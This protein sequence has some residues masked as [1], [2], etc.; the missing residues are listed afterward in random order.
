MRSRPLALC[1]ALALLAA[2][3]CTAIRRSDAMDTERMLAAAGFQL[4]LA[5]SPARLAKVQGLPQRK[6][7][8]VP[9]QGENRFVYA[10]AQFCKCLYAGTEKAYDRYQKLAIKQ[11]I[12]DEQLEASLDWDDWG[13][14][15]PWW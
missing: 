14:W 4:K 11:E 13:M 1:A 15:G 9:F 12:A 10:D 2:V 7:T 6:L 3:G 8:R 5:D